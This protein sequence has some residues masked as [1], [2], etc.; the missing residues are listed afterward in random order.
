MQAMISINS[1][2]IEILTNVK[3]MQES[4]KIINELITFKSEHKIK[5]KNIEKSMDKALK[6]IKELEHKIIK[7]G[8]ENQRPSSVHVNFPALEFIK[9]YWPAIVVIGSIASFLLSFIFGIEI[10]G[11]LKK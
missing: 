3:Q 6:D 4:L 2:L 7:F 9:N 5:I 10:Q 8:I 11:V 1:V